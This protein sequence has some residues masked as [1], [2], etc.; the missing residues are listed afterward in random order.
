MPTTPPKDAH[1][2]EDYASFLRFLPA[3]RYL[4]VTGDRTLPEELVAR[5][6]PT[7]RLE[8]DFLFLAG[9]APTRDLCDRLIRRAPPALQ[10]R[11]RGIVDRRRL[12]R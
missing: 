2:L 8:T 11:L 1:T 5:L 12:R 9:N 6:I 10:P 3:R 4:D 7:A